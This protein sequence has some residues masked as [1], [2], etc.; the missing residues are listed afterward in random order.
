MRSTAFFVGAAIVSDSFAFIPFGRPSF[1]DEEIS[2][3]TAV[4]RSGW[5]GMGEQT[6][7]FERE[8]AAFVE[9]EHVVSLSS[10]TAALFLSLIAAGVG[11]GDE[12]ICPSLTWCSTAN[13]ALYLG[14]RPVFCDV[15]AGSLLATP[16][17]I[18]ARLSPRTRAVVVVHFGGLAV[19]VKA[20]RRVLPR[21]IALIEDAAHALGATYPTGGK[22]GS[23]GNLVCFSFYANKNLSTREGG[24]I[25]LNDAR[26]ADRLGS[27]RQHGLPSN[28]W[29]RFT[30]RGRS[31]ES[32]TL[33]ELGY[34]LNYTDLQASIGR[35]QLRRQEEFQSRRSAIAAFYAE[36]LAERKP[37]VALQDQILSRGHSRHLFVIRLQ[38]DLAGAGRNALVQRARERGV[39]LSVH[40]PPLHRMPLYEDRSVPP[41]TDALADRLVTLPISA[42][43]SDADAERVWR[44]VEQE[45]PSRAPTQRSTVAQRIEFVRTAPVGGSEVSQDERYAFGGRLTKA[46]P[47]QLLVDV[48]E[49]CNLACVHCPHPEFKKSEHY[50]RRTLDPE[51]ND[52]LVDEVRAYGVGA[53][54][55]IR[56]ASNG[57]PLA[58]PHI[59]SMLDTAARRSGVL[60]TL[61]TN[62]TLLTSARAERI[63]ESGVAVVDISIDAI[64]PQTYAAIRVGGKLQDVEAN[65]LRL[66]DLAGQKGSRTKVVVSFVEQPNNQSEVDTFERVWRDRGA[67]DVVIRRLHSCSG[68]K[69]ALAVE[70]R[71]LA[72]AQSR[73]PCLY[74]WERIGLNAAGHLFFCPSDW[75]HGST[76]ADYRQTSIREAWEGDFYRD[77][78]RAHL[79]NDY[80][81]HAFCGQCPDWSATRW[82]HEGRSYADMIK[83]FKVTA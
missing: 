60:V 1:G 32:L 25:A 23:S 14:A 29:T 6:I 45:L 35:V 27:L 64:A 74:P 36:R 20:L 52:R 8:L 66:I 79:E 80:S 48:T 71:E 68:A 3:V 33:Q 2:A 53:T 10:C 41:V 63:V 72:T 31:P 73:R 38:P 69:Q 57:E 47:S 17:S 78:R 28:A 7:A 58:H 34:K 76:L 37:E 83:D 82:P 19:D 50:G 42:S 22:V 56:Y 51:L 39:G 54:E 11:E 75:V 81:R 55:Y 40:Y 12:V 9:A 26:L 62:G 61:T 67:S 4:L 30:Q 49:V 70:R 43:M 16:E 18:L 21:H 44:I 24:A 77:L 15:D 59:F 13:A 46:F 65:V 5:V